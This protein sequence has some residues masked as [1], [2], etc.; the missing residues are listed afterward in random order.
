MLCKVLLLMVAETD[1]EEKKLFNKVIIFV[2]FACKKHSR[3]FITL[4]LN[5]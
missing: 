3:S 4:R 2:F 5:H 1:L